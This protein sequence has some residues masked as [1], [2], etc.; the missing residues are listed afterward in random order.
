MTSLDGFRNDGKQNRLYGSQSSGLDLSASGFCGQ[1]GPI[2][3]HYSALG[4]RDATGSVSQVSMET[5]ADSHTGE[6]KLIED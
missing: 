1:V 5:K 4:D 6:L 3:Q 2:G